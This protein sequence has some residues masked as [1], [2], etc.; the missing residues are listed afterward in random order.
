MKGGEKTQTLYADMNKKKRRRKH[1]NRIRTRE[2]DWRCYTA[3]TKG[4]MNQGQLLGA[5]KG[6]Q[7]S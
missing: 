3:D 7:F 1:D 6:A 2:K 5:D 4:A